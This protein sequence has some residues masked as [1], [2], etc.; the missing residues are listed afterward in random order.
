VTQLAILLPLL[1]FGA[2]AAA[3]AIVLRRAGTIVARTREIEGFRSAVTDLAARV[4]TS[5][6]GAAER[7]DGVRRG[8]V[9][10]DTVGPTIEAS[11]DAVSRYL[12]EA[13]EL[14]APP[15]GVAI[16]DGII[17]DLERAGRALEMVDH[18]VAILLQVRRRGRELEAQTSIKRGYLNLLHAREA[19]DRHAALARSL[20]TT[21]EGAAAVSSS[22]ARNHRT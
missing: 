13:H 3:T 2:L 22:A 4:D 19:I 9:G 20:E 14:K 18:G 6:A 8:Q 12:D 16:R 17:E 11:A 10:A 15:A 5:L 7:I 1:A 21:T